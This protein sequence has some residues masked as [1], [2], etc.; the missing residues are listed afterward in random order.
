M[1]TLKKLRESLS[2][3]ERKRKEAENISAMPEK[4]KIISNEFDTHKIKGNIGTYQKVGDSH[5]S[6]RSTITVPE[7]HYEK[8]KNI[9]KSLGFGK[10]HHVAIKSDA[11]GDW[12]K[13]GE[14]HS[15]DKNWTGD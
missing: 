7:E 10:S 5:G 1:T 4:N 8:A 15:G 6:V 3:D 9:I 13:S 2:F 14:V 11:G 12:H